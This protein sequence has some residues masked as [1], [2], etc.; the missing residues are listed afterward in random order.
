MSYRQEPLA[1]YT[2]PF[3]TGAPPEGYRYIP[4][5]P[6]PMETP[7]TI[8]VDDPR[9]PDAMKPQLSST[10][11]GPLLVSFISSHRSSP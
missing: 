5:P 3:V 6:R 10:F 4:A 9:Q 2:I 8:S 7:M 11:S 1:L